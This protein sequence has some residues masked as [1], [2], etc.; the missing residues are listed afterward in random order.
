[1]GKKES[2]MNKVNNNINSEKRSCGGRGVRVRKET[3]TQ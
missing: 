2:G 3:H 1:M